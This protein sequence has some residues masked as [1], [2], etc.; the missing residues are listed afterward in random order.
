MLA[1]E[2]ANL[3]L[4]WQENLTS[5]EMPP[6]WMWAFGDEL[7]IWFEDVDTQRKE[8]FGSASAGGD[9]ETPMMRNELARGR[10]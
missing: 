10:G 1:Y 7:E 4:D 5:D 2:H 3:I 6:R 8:R 9:E